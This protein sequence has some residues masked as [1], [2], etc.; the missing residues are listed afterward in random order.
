MGG[1]LGAGHLL[2]LATPHAHRVGMTQIFSGRLRPYPG[3]PHEWP[4]DKLQRAHAVLRS[5]RAMFPEFGEA[6]VSGSDVED[7]WED[8]ARADAA[9]LAAG[10]DIEVLSANGFT[11]DVMRRRLGP[12]SIREEGRHKID[13]FVDHPLLHRFGGREILRG[14]IDSTGE[15][16]GP[17]LLS[18]LADR[19]RRGDR[20]GV[21]KCAIQKTGIWR[22][23]LTEDPATILTALIDE[24]DWTVIRLE[25]VPGAFVAQEA[26]PMSYEYRL[27]IVDGQVVAGAGCVEEFTSLDARGQQFDTRVRRSRGTFSAYPS[28]VEDRPDVVAELVEFGSTVA[29]AFGGTVVADVAQSDRGPILVELNGLPNSGLYASD[30]WAVTRALIDA[31]DRGY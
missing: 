16:E 7:F 4:D 24:G 20:Y 10:G 26:L 28:P 17:D 21:V 8:A 27:F 5:C 25:G 2:K 22:V 23:P 1:V 31:N 12:V 18:W 11:D 15:A 19:Y 14:T 6:A 3:V 29:E 13:T 30:V 9:Y